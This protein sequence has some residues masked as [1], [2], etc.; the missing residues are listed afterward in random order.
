MSSLSNHAEGQCVRVVMY[1]D[2]ITKSRV[3]FLQVFY[4]SLV[5][6]PTDAFVFAAL[7]EHWVHP[8]GPKREVGRYH[9]PSQFF[10]PGTRL[11]NLIQAV[12]GASPP[13]VFTAEIC[14]L[15]YTPIV[16]HG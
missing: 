3:T 7:T 1:N 14:G 13:L 12:E 10:V 11:G 16:R 5:T 8:G 6:D 2:V 9:I 4:G 15:Y